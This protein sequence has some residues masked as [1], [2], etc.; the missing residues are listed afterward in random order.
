MFLPVCTML[1]PPH[2]W[3]VVGSLSWVWGC[4]CFSSCFFLPYDCFSCCRLGPAPLV[5]PMIS[6]GAQSLMKTG[7][8]SCALGILVNGTWIGWLLSCRAVC[9][10]SVHVPFQS[11]SP[12]SNLY[13][14]SSLVL[15]MSKD[16]HLL[17]Y[18]PSSSK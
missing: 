5:T 15:V 7:Q 10:I 4:T 14:C 13:V 12:L 18:C 8:C 3:V 9:L 1:L 2:W 17:L 6:M 16:I 11:M